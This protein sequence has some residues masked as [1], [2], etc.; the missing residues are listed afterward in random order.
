MPDREPDADPA[1][2]AIDLAALRAGDAVAWRA[3]YA[4]LFP[5]ARHAAQRRLGDW[6]EAEDA[7]AATLL[8]F[9]QRRPA[10][11]SFDEARAWCALVAGRHAVSLVR[12]AR[13]AKRGGGRDRALDKLAAEEIPVEVPHAKI[14]EMLDLEALLDRLE[15]RDRAIVLAHLTEGESSQAIAA[16]HGVADSTVR[17]IVGQALRLL[18][19]SAASTLAVDFAIISMAAWLGATSIPFFTA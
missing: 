12:R 1:A 19:R 9:Y 11:A 2:E 6:H 5:I 17:G 16:R 18:R 7:A 10:V 3:A 15:P 14:R 13:A 4:R 8:L